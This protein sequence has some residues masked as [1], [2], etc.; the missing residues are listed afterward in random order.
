MKKFACIFY[1]EDNEF[2]VMLSDEKPN[3]EKVVAFD[4]P[5]IFKDYL[6]ALAF[7]TNDNREI[8]FDCGNPDH[9]I[10][11][12]PNCSQETLDYAKQLGGKL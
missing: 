1:C 3:R 10:E 12:V 11:Q 6:E 7:V 4:Q 9:Y 8:V 2:L 5:I